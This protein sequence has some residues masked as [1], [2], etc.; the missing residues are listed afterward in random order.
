M[1]RWPSVVMMDVDGVVVR[2][3]PADGRHPF[4]ELD[5]DLGI[6]WEA[7][8]RCFF[9]V[10]WPAIVTG[11]RPLKPALTEVLA[12][13][14][15]HVVPDALVRYWFENDSRLDHAVLDAIGGLR[16]RG[17]RVLLATNQEHMRA[18]Y[19]MDDMGLS[20]HVDGI[21]YSA[22]IG[23]RK[24]SPEFYRRATALA[25]VEAGEI[26]LVD[27]TQENVDGAVAAGWRAVH[28]TDAATAGDLPGL[29][30]A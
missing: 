7:L 11:E 19:L 8:Q 21:V 12:D 3:R 6:S 27:D 18:R 2:G 13:I 1:S 4:A 30:G 14:A 22:A 20:G 16:K 17:I 29:I 25:A 28:W 10:H 26:V 24:P 23:H 15:P 5:R 9:A